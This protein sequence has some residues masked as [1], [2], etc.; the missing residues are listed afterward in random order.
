MT[1]WQGLTVM[2]IRIAMADG[3]AGRTKNTSSGKTGHT[4]I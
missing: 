3:N 4:K 2:L 1:I